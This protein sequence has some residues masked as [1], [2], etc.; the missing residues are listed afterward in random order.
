MKR[1]LQISVLFLL[2][3]PINV[4]AA[5]PEQIKQDFSPLN[6]VIIMPVGEEYLIDLD[7]SVNLHEGDILTL[8]TAGEQVIHP[9]TKE[10]LGS[11]DVVRGYLQVT[12]VKSGYS[13]TKIITAQTTP[14]KG[15]Q[16]KRFEQ[17]PVIFKSNAANA[18][19]EKDL[20]LGLPHLNWL[21][22][23]PQ[24]MPL[25]SFSLNDNKLVVENTE[26]LVLKSYPFTD[27][28]LTAPVGTL[29]QP[30][31]FTIGEK[32]KKK[33]TL[34]NQGVDNLLGV[35][36]FGKKDK[37]LT[38]PG[39]T[40]SLQQQNNQIW[41]GPNL[42]GNPAGIAIGDFDNDGLQEI[43]VAMDNQVK[44]YR[45][46]DGQLKQADLIDF[47]G[48]VHLLSLDTIDLNNN[49]YPEL[50]LTAN[51]GEKLS[52]QVIEFS[53]GAYTIIENQIPWF[54][55]VVD[56]PQEG[57]TLVAQLLGDSETPFFDKPFRTYLENGKLTRGHDLPLP[58]NLNIFS[59]LSF[60]GTNNDLLYATISP[61][62]YLSV[63][64]PQGTQLWE[65][66]GHWGGTF[67]F[68]YNAKNLNK[69][70]VYP[71]YI[72]QRL[73]SLPSGEILVPQNEGSRGL[74]RFRNFNKSRIVAMK[75]DGFALTES[76]QT[77]EQPGY[78]A[79]Y[80][81]SDADNDGDDELVVAVRY[82]QKNAFQKGRSAI[83]IYE[84]SH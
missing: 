55:C 8:V 50:Y 6:G 9:V 61:D 56:L 48:G 4:L 71:I 1:L 52:S 49:G 33:K 75:W 44:I 76:W 82:S 27:G 15:D 54:L 11:L 60:T 63:I 30:G 72:Q 68:F 78:L 67:Q 20:K 5:L 7:A 73:S 77:A 47:P 26:G 81:L 13:Y 45:L 24:Q 74:K 29:Y 2:C 12:Q 3:L 17:V 46:V 18:P 14:Q 51:V 32:P 53:N 59:V 28:Q 23:N 65:A 19:V 70:I 57:P 66:D 10:V 43:A 40:Q 22:G 79:D 41:T 21:T 84:L 36:G 34:L 42:D 58:G 31:S 16:V 25:L 35:A 80:S 38:N 83:V 69:E 39:I 62:D 64:S 37:R